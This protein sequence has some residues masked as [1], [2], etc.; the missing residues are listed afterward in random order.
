MAINKMSLFLENTLNYL[1]VHGIILAINSQIN[2][3]IDSIYRKIY[4]KNGKTNII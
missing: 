1:G 2:L 3:V 4:R